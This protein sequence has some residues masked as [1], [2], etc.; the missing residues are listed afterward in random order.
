MST[1]NVASKRKK[2]P[3]TKLAPAEDG[4]GSYQT[5]TVAEGIV[6]KVLA[7]FGHLMPVL[8]HRSRDLL[9][10]RQL[11]GSEVKN[12]KE[13]VYAHVMLFEEPSHRSEVAL[14]GQ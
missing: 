11:A 2:A 3:T 9:F 10:G 4:A 12:I 1:T 5:L 6:P 8:P 7:L 14:L 13:I